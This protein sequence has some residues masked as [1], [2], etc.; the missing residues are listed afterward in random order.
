MNSRVARVSFQIVLLFTIVGCVYIYVYISN[1]KA[2]TSIKWPILYVLCLWHCQ[3]LWVCFLYFS[4]L[5]LTTFFLS[6]YSFLAF[7]PFVSHS[8]SHFTWE[9]MFFFLVWSQ[10]LTFQC[11]AKAIHTKVFCMRLSKRQSHWI[12]NA[13]IL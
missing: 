9:S 11:F 12:Y 7:I 8:L 6:S 3:Y 4:E 1:L 2:T 13:S 5:P 10:F